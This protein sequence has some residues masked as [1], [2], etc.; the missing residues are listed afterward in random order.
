ME[1]CEG[2]IKEDTADPS[3]VIFMCSTGI[4]DGL[5]VLPPKPMPK[6]SDNH[7][8]YKLTFDLLTLKGTGK[9]YGRL[10]SFEPLHTFTTRPRLL[11]YT[12]T[13]DSLIVRLK[14]GEECEACGIENEEGTSYDV[15]FEVPLDDVIE[16]DGE[17]YYIIRG[18]M[19]MKANR[20]NLDPDVVPEKYTRL[21]SNIVVPLAVSEST[22][23]A[24]K[25]LDAA[26]E[27]IRNDFSVA[28]I[29]KKEK[30]VEKQ[31][32]LIRDELDKMG[33]KYEILK[34]EYS[35]LTVVK[36][37]RRET[38]LEVKEMPMLRQ[39][40]GCNMTELHGEL[41][42][43][44]N[45]ET[46]YPLEPINPN[47]VIR[48]HEYFVVFKPIT[49]RFAV[50]VYYEP[51]HLFLDEYHEAIATDGRRSL[52]V[53]KKVMKCMWCGLTVQ[54]NYTKT[55]EISVVSVNGELRYI[56]TD[57]DN[58]ELNT[59]DEILD[60]VRIDENYVEFPSG[61]HVPVTVGTEVLKKLL[62]V[63]IRAANEKEAFAEQSRILFAELKKSGY[64]MVLKGK[65]KCIVISP[66]GKKGIYEY[67]PDFYDGPLSPISETCYTARKYIMHFLREDSVE[68]DSRR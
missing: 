39:I 37:G 19:P 13:R 63:E 41:V 59:P 47:N 2:V 38:N 31:L 8:R 60:G 12:I 21:A 14:T 6:P 56:F 40:H 3:R 36:I 66:D 51:H 67:G 5:I 42:F 43:N 54:T 52:L 58:F 28:A 53:K 48:G 57:K 62:E 29:S 26:Y 11:T 44:C 61:L 34:D 7:N 24:L 4:Y 17:P 30:I 18:Y 25:E 50:A 15:E 16:I 45:M 23:R 27:K 35:I 55:D 1:Q 33:V 46:V 10:V 9:Q 49:D 65:G 22:M 20:N 32:Q 68:G 64:R